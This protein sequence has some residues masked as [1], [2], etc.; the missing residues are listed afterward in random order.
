MTPAARL[1]AA[2]EIL[3][4]WHEHPGKIDRRLAEW[5]RRHRFA[6]SK[7]RAAIAD[8]VY[9]CLRHWRS[10]GALCEASSIARGRAHVL[11]SALREHRNLAPVQEIFGQGVHAPAALTASELSAARAFLTA[12]PLPDWPA[13]LMPDLISSVPDP[14]L[15]IARQRQRSPL[16]LRVNRLKTEP[17]KII[18]SL[19]AMG[20][21]AAQGPLSPDCLRLEKPRSL[22]G[23][24]IYQS[25]LIEIQDAASQAV[26][27]LAAQGMA[28][29]SLMLD[30]CAGAGGKSLA[31]AACA[32]QARFYAWDIDRAR[33]QDLGPR[34]KRA[35]ARIEIVSSGKLEG[36][37]GRCDRVLVDAPCSGSGTWSRDPD[38]KW[39]FTE[40]RL[41]ELVDMQA[42][43]LDEAATFVRPGGWLVY[44]TCSVLRAENE[45]AI[46]QFAARAPG[47]FAPVDLK[48][49]WQAAGLGTISPF[50]AP[51]CVRFD[52]VAQQ[53]DGFFVAIL[54]RAPKTR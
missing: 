34:A 48:Q 52:P 37:R 7:D 14:E 5:G 43:V 28:P 17:S 39:L 4:D 10:D 2:I 40:A 30:L 31:M 21:E 20:C 51:G 23:T 25:G 3:Q 45:A 50:S 35:G 44:A 53:T 15:L 22:T 6:G 38:Q 47:Q 8:R 19:Q 33:M 11:A 1:A 24:E 16:D 18:K 26:A 42:R 12:A 27:L 46:E 13:W 36:L 29:G 9:D 54:H 41:A 32:P 49:V